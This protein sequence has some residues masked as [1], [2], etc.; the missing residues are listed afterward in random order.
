MASYL[1]DSSEAKEILPRVSHSISFDRGGQT[2]RTNSG[3]GRDLLELTQDE[4]VDFSSL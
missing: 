3:Q 4:S 2:D 1:V